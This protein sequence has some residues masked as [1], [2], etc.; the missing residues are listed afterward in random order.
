MKYLI[1][2]LLFNVSCSSLKSSQ[3]YSG[4]V[5]T[6]L[7]GFIGMEIGKKTSPNTQSQGLNKKIGGLSG[8]AVGLL[9][10]YALGGIMFKSDP[11]NFQGP[12]ITLGNKENKKSGLIDPN[13]FKGL[14]L[15]SLSISKNPNIYKVPVSNTLPDS[16]K[17]SV[18]KQ[19]VIEHKIPS[20]VLKR[21]DGTT[22]ILNEAT[23]IEHRYLEN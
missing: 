11:E 23:A 17:G 13:N 2:I 18:Y 5:G 12:D 9:A 3:V 15:S 21:A 16:M 10:G 22:I 6:L 8:A 4:L 19:L 20:Q 1:L 7:G 14:D